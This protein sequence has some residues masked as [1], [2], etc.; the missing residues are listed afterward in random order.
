[1]LPMLFATCHLAN[2]EDP[3]H[4][5]LDMCHSLIGEFLRSLSYKLGLFLIFF[6]IN[7]GALLL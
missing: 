1:M 6:P 7:R 2:G 3:F 5:R 4:S